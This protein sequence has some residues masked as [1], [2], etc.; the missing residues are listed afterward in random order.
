MDDARE[1][2]CDSYSYMQVGVRAVLVLDPKRVVSPTQVDW[3]Q[4]SSCYCYVGRV[5]IE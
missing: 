5:R 1:C 3:R 4:H 2:G